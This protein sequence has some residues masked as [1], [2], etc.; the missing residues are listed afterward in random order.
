[1][2]TFRER[3]RQLYLEREDRIIAARAEGHTL[4][5]IAVELHLSKERIRQI[6]EHAAKRLSNPRRA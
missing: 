6:L 2:Q 1:M 5:E 3:V 4:E